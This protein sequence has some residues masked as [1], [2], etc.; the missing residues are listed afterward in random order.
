MLDPKGN[1]AVY[2]LYSYVRLC[3]ILRKGGYTA[4]ELREGEFK[5]TNEYERYLGCSIIKFVDVIQSACDL[6]A[7][8]WICDY[9]YDLATKISECY[10]K[11]KILDEEHKKTRLQMCECL[12]TIMLVCF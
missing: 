3:S 4:E 8:N 5:F 12:R 9:T 6:L 7:I 11:Y 2:L 1:T 10:N